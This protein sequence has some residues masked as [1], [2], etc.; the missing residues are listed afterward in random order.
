MKTAAAELRSHM[1]DEVR[2][3]MGSYSPDSFKTSASGRK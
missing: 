1:K 2:D 3:V